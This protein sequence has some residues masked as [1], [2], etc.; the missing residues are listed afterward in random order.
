MVNVIRGESEKPV[1]SQKLADYFERRQ[2]LSGTLYLGYPI[3]GTAEGGYQVDALL[4]TEENGIVIFN[5]VEGPNKHVAVEESQDESVTKL[6]SKLL[7][8]K[9]LTHKR[10]LMVEVGVATYA[11]AWNKKPDTISD[12]YPV[13][14]SEEDL[15]ALLKSQIWSKNGYFEKLN[16][17]LQ[18]ITTIRKG[19]KRT[20]LR[21]KDSRGSKL[22]R[23]EESIANL[24]QSQ[25]AAVIETVDGVQRI[26][27]LAG[28]G[29]TIVMALKVAYLHAKHPDWDIAVTFNTRSLKGQFHHLINTFSY[30]HISEEPN[31][32]K[33]KVVHAWGSPSMEG[34]YYEF[35]KKH[36]IEYLDFEMSKRFAPLYGQE[37]DKVCEDALKKVKKF[38]EY[39]DAI[40]VDE[41]QDFSKS[42]LNLCHGILRYPKRLTYA[43]DE[44]QNLS[45]KVME[46]AEDSFGKDKNGNPIVQLT[47]RPGQPKRDI[48]L[49]RC[50]RNPRPVLASAHAL[51]FGIYRKQGLIQMFEHSEL[52]KE[53]GY[54]VEEGTLVD[55]Q[56]VKLS[57]TSETSPQFLESHSPVEDLLTFKSFQNEDQQA[58]WLIDQICK[59]LNEDE[60][61]PDDIMVIHTNPLTTKKAVGKP[62]AG[63]FAK[64][65]NSTVA[66]VTTSPDEFFS[67]DSV[68][69]TSIYRAKG[70][71]AA[72]V[73]VINAHECFAG[74]Q[75]A[76]KRNILFT[77]MTRSKAWLRVLGI[78]D[79]MDSLV[80]EF[81]EIKAN[82]FS[83]D[84][85]YPTEPER[86][87]M[88][89]VHRDMGPKELDQLKERKKSLEQ[90]LAALRSGQIYK[91]DLPQDVLDQ[92]KDI[93]FSE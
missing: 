46:S 16:S 35:C 52:W 12:E 75:L 17:V 56:H 61:R 85:V 88:N 31:W 59:N 67:E 63:L 87:R 45:G 21:K 32:E 29:K 90:L 71:E 44:L 7:Q 64:K 70:N 15:A 42:F 51:G 38:K 19:R 8:H 86:R 18:A 82:E 69:F 28:S 54:S 74:L 43:Y 68:V 3:I 65:I 84:F 58:E 13:V 77:A 72:M 22:R 1:S 9:D 24:D 76:R 33:I 66:G 73:Y 39:Y 6:Q 60:L 2:D 40:L 41:A 5:L 47:N 50:Y 57:R 27:G 91:E 92:L 62:R 81:R 4:V 48:I 23:L 20:Y 93:L 80:E 78:G 79:S 89:I 11:P 34:I 26:R 25:S 14:I 53:I 49:E 83:L 55:G 30:E 37:L 36:G 10:Q